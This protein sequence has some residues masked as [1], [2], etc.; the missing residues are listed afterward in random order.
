MSFDIPFKAGDG[1]LLIDSAPLEQ[2]VLAGASGDII[3][4]TAPTGKLI[5]L[6]SLV[7]LGSGGNEAGI[8][9]IRDGETIIDQKELSDETVVTSSSIF[10]ILRSGTVSVNNSA[11]LIREVIGENIKVNK[12]TGSTGADISWAYE[13]VT[14]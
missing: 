13:V 2:T 4:I 10:A 3:D 12:N 8:S 5:R 1:P 14:R 9:V 7:R 11:G 6:Y